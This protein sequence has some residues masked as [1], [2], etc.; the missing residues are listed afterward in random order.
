MKYGF[1]CL[2]CAI[3]AVGMMVCP[4]TA[5][6]YHH[7]DESMAAFQSDSPMNDQFGDEMSA[8]CGVYAGLV[9]AVVEEYPG[10]VFSHEW[11]S[12]GASASAFDNP[13]GVAVDSF[14]NV[15]VADTNNHCIRKFDSKGIHLLSW[16]SEGYCDGEFQYPHGIA[17][18]STDKIY[19]SDNRNRIQKFTH[20]GRFLSSWG[21]YDD[22][23]RESIFPSGIAIDDSNNVYV[24]DTYYKCIHKFTSD[25]T[26]SGSWGSEGQG[27]GEFSRPEGVAVDSNGNV[28]VVDSWNNCVQ[29][30]TS[31]G[32]ILSMWCSDGSGDVEFCHP[33]GIAIDDMDNVY[34]TDAYSCRVQK[35]DKDGTFLISW[36]SN[37]DNDSNLCLPSG[38]AVSPSS[39]LYIADWGKDRIQKYALD[40]TYLSSWGSWTSGIGEFNTP[41][42]I[43]IDT[44]DT[45]YVADTNNNRIQTF[46]A[47]GTFCSTWGSEG[48]GDGEFT[49]PKG[50]A[51]DSAGNSYIADSWNNRIQSFSSDGTFR[52]TWGTAGSDEGAFNQPSGIAV[53]S[54]DTI[55]VAD[56]GNHRIQT[57]DTDGSYLTSWG[58][59]GSSEG[60]FEYPY[61]IAV[62]ASDRVFVADTNNHRIQVFDRDGTYLMSWGS[63]GSGYG[64]FMYPRGIT[65]DSS[66]DVYVADT[67]N[68]RIQKF[69]AN[70]TYLTSWG[71]SGDGAG[72]FDSPS[73][74]SIDSAGNVYVVDTNNHRIETFSPVVPLVANFSVNRTL[75]NPP[76]TVQFTDTS[77][78]TPTEWFWEFGDGATSTDQHPIHSY[79]AVGNYTVNLTVT[80]V[81]AQDKISQAEL[82]TVF[83][84]APKAEFDLIRNSIAF[85]QNNT[86]TP[87]TYAANLTYRLHAL[88]NDSNVTLGNLT[89]IAA[90]GNITDID[91]EQYATW[92]SSYVEWT[93]PASWVMEPG[94]GLN[95]SAGTATTEDTFYNHILTRTCNTSELYKDSVQRTSVT[96][97]FND[98]NFA[99]VFLGFTSLNATN[100]SAKIIPESISTN[101]PL[102][103]PLPADGDYH[104]KLDKGRLVSGTE[105]SLTFDTEVRLN[106]SAVIYRPLVY[107]Q[108]DMGNYSADVGESCMAEVPATM[109]PA[110]ASWFSFETDTCCNWSV[111]RQNHFLSVI[112]GRSVKIPTPMPVANFTADRVSGMLPV[113]VQFNDTSTGFP[114]EWH[115]NFGDRETSS[116]QCPNHTYT[117]AGN[118]NVSL[119]VTNIVGN[120]T[121][122]KSDLITVSV[123]KAEFDLNHNF[124]A[125][126]TGNTFTPGT[127]TANLTYRLHAETSTPNATLGNLIYTAGTGNISWVDYPLYATWDSSSAYWIFPLEYVITSKNGFDTR[128]GTSTTEEC[129]YNHT[130]TRT[131]N[132]SIFRTDAVQHTNVTVVF[133]DLDFESLFVGFAGADD[134]NVTTAI[135]PETVTT[136]APLA[137][138]LPAGGACHLHLNTS[139]LATGTEYSFMFDTRIHL[140][141]SPVMHKPLVYVWEGMSHETADIGRSYTASVPHDM[142]PADANEFSVQTNRTCDWTVVRQNNLLSMIEGQSQRVPVAAFSASPCVGAPPLNVTFMDLSTENPRAWAWTFGDGANATDQNPVHT[143]LHDG[144]Y[145]VSLSVND[146]ES[147]ATKP[148]F[149]RVTSLLL[150]DANADGT[151]NQVDTLH[152]LK[153]V[154][155]IDDVPEDG[156][157]DFERTDVHWNGMVD[158]GDAMFI[159]QYNVGLRDQWFALI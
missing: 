80:K 47:N 31:C 11:G 98:L 82:I 113:T 122:T 65:V 77:E 110:D 18:D 10:Y 17:I 159:A 20:D 155:G 42:G 81:G 100:V 2:F 150:G 32:M 90:A 137:E 53:D 66:D 45:V 67:W 158:I 120:D 63:E 62:N 56:F 135:I 15:Y 49:Y 146:G 125:T 27:L 22:E 85:A 24:A 8:E 23:E 97:T 99:S 30:F 138:P 48:S 72:A 44:A 102:V 55:Y 128:A 119:T 16:G 114:T 149:I 70:G 5:E 124:V 60:A 147:I 58:S 87:G 25:G 57:F 43:A 36:G 3:L 116:V 76:L 40:G 104:L 132:V 89:C 154:V 75:G 93:F 64:D 9:S 111:S 134:A 4:V 73:A 34:I 151:V 68:N 46:D 69:T 54:T 143:Y 112:E 61:G 115:W 83:I 153:E 52:S 94:C 131:T 127:Y 6:Q 95:V 109:L 136:N 50:V 51:I 88:N 84:P 139:G 86:F 14:G 38:V 1:F 121:V 148:D 117:S 130:I 103:D 13:H 157:D 156:T 106:R 39:D 126:T 28:Y 118:Y 33:D 145:P 107:I 92:N 91:N 19:V 35:F 71:A 37:G 141:G 78:N 142:L 123:P 108:E 140:N 12:Y 101:I 133:D 152:V 96:L 29:K 59:E 144:V 21:S 74:I 41:S 105:Y 79:S 26:F 129:I 7:S